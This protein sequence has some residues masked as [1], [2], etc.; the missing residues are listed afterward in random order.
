MSLGYDISL[1][2]LGYKLT[3]I[4]DFFTMRQH[5]DA[6]ISGVAQPYHSQYNPWVA[7]PSWAWLSSIIASMT[8]H[9]HRVA[10]KSHRQ[11]HRQHCHQHDSTS[12]LR[13]GQVAPA[14]SSPAW[15]SSIVASMTWHQHH[16]TTKSPR[17]RRRQHDSAAP[18]Q[19][20]SVSKSPRQLRRSMTWHLH[21]TTANVTSVA[22]SQMS[23][24]QCHHQH[25]SVASSPAWLSINIMK[26]AWSSTS[27][28]HD[29]MKQAWSSTSIMHDFSGKPTR[30]QLILIL[31]T[32][33]F[34]SRANASVLMRCLAP[35]WSIY[36]SK[37]RVWR[38]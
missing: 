19:Y 30:C 12:T 10:A 17:Q 5:L 34:G 20:D 38:L 23:P 9:L 16:A 31:F 18:R 11:C 33:M 21:H 29:F 32:F 36:I 35:P 4:F 24:R 13:H 7:A 2:P 15:F 14:T 37:T 28:M 25:N 3:Q 6:S 1:L 22:Q 27:T 8:Q 26:R